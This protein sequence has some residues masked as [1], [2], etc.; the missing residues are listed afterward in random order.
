MALVHTVPLILLNSV[1]YVAENQHTSTGY[2]TEPFAH[3]VNWTITGERA[4]FEA[5]GGSWVVAIVLA[6]VLVVGLVLAWRPL[7][8]SELRRQAA[9]PGALLLG[10]P[11]LFWLV[12]AQR[13]WLKGEVDSSKF[14]HLSLAFALPALAVAANAIA[15]HWRVLTPVVAVVLLAGVP[16]NIGKFPYDGPFQPGFFRAEKV[17]VLGAAYSDLADQVP[18]KVRPYTAYYTAPGIDLDFL[19]DARA[20]GRLPKPPAMS[21]RER[22]EALIRVAVWQRRIVPSQIP[23][24]RVFFAPLTFDNLPKGTRLVITEW[25]SINYGEGSVLFDPSAGQI[26]EIE[27]PDLKFTV[28]NA[29]NAPSNPVTFCH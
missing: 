14:L 29:Q 18:G 1:W 24:C 19:L 5:F 17:G 22:D 28:T 7:A 15:R 6:L 11:V 23:D 13:Y 4:S 21:Q 25:V 16:G 9:V 20:T 10:G 2:P 12:S 8:F 3:G 26:L 27:V